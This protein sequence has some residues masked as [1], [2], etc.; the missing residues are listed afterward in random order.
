MERRDF[1]AEVYHWLVHEKGYPRPSV[2]PEA[3]VATR[4]GSTPVRADFA[5]LDIQ[6]S[7]FVAIIEV[8]ASRDPTALRSAI[9]QLASFRELLGKP[10]IP[11]YLFF[12]PNPASGMSF[13]ISQVLPDG[14]QKQV[15]L[16]DFP[17]YPALVSGD[18]SGTKATRRVAARAAVDSFFLVCV[19]LSIVASAA[20][21]LDVSGALEL[22]PKQLILATAAAGVLVLPFAAKLN[23][24]GVEFER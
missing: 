19:G 1:E 6:R 24:L 14:T 20:L 8:K 3:I 16:E 15:A 11:V 17:L 5:V 2:Q 9:S 23:L 18:R 21:W 13:E 4:R 22:S 12:K 7:E 10:F